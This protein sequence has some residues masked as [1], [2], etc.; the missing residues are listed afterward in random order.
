MAFDSRLRSPKELPLF[1]IGI[2]V[3]AIVYLAL[4]ISMVGVI[5]IAIGALFVLAAQALFLAHVHGNGVRVSEQQLPDLYA[6]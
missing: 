2:A 3:S 5:Y 4:I 6:R 1:R